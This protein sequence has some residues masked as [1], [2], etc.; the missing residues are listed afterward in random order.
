VGNRYFVLGLKGLGLKGLGLKGL[1]LKGLGLK[2]R[3]IKGFWHPPPWELEDPHR[4][5][6]RPHRGN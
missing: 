3:N 2:H 4:G 5:N 6:Y 1:G